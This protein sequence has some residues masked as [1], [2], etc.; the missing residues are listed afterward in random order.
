[1]IADPKVV[2]TFADTHRR[3]VIGWLAITKLK[4]AL[5]LD[6]KRA[7]LQL[8]RVVRETHE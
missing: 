1:M 7:R 2:E 5:L 3:Q 6:F 8:K 4:L